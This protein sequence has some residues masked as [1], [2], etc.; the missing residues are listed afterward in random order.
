MKRIAF[1]IVTMSLITYSLISCVKAGSHGQILRVS[2]GTRM[3]L[4]DIVED[5]KGVRLVFVGE[6]HDE[7]GHHQAQLAVIRALKEAG[8]SVAVGLEMFRSDSQAH[9]DQWIGGKLNQDAFQKVYYANWSS[10]WVLYR[11]IFLY[12]RQTKI[13]M[14][15]LNIPPEISRQVAGKGFSSLTPEQVGQLPEVSC[16]VDETYMNFIR[17]AFGLH[18][19]D[20]GK[21]FMYFCEAQIVWDTAMAWHLLD[22][23][24]KDPTHTIVVLAGSGHAWKRGIPEQVT[25]QSDV[26]YRVILPEI[27]GRLESEAVTLEDADYL[28]LQ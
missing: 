25:R 27:Q 3:T 4:A 11:D 18:G 23:L 10:D 19:H 9:L 26:S 8:I 28:W 5:L 15:G 13:P 14:I 2:D 6:L 12:A 20:Q 22:F 24:K 1:A 17:Q 21:S 7:A 16:R